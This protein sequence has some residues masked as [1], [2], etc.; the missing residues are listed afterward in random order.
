MR[1]GIFIIV[2]FIVISIFIGGCNK[3]GAVDLTT[4]TST[5]ISTS[6]TSVP[7]TT[8]TI[9]IGYACNTD[10]DCVVKDVHNCCGYYPRCV[11]K[12]YIPDI[13]A[14]QSKCAEKGYASVCGWPEITSCSCIQN[15]C[16]S[17]QDGKIV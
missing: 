10:S 11:N 1:R 4:S 15:T 8:S 14:V 16:K 9:M 13:G 5:M 2:L 12:D 3:N 17:L 7:Q 6:I